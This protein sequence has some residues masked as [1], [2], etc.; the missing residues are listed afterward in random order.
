MS[1]STR[2]EARYPVETLRNPKI[3]V[4]PGEEP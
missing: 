1:V 2:V 3:H 4:G